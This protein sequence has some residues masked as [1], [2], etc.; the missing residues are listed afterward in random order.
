MSMAKDVKV[1]SRPNRAISSKR[2]A[3]EKLAERGG[4]VMA[5]AA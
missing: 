2:R 3:A 1:V 5:R 4:A